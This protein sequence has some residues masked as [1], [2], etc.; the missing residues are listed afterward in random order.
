[1]LNGDQI[2]ALL[3]EEG[4]HVYR[5]EVKR[6]GNR[7]LTMPGESGWAGFSDLS[8]HRQSAY[9]LQCAARGPAA[10]VFRCED[11]VGHEKTIRM[12]G[13]ASWM[14]VLLDEPT[15]VY[16]DFDNPKNFAADGPTPGTWLFSN[17]QSGPVGREA[18]GVPAQVKAPG[19]WWGLKFNNDQLAL[20]LITPETAASYRIAP[21]AGA[22]GVG[23]ENSPPAHHFVTLAGVLKGSPAETMNRL[24]ST[25]DLKRP[26]SVD[27]YGLEAR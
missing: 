19:T 23:I 14:E 16:W 20:G 13:G 3:S 10:V 25:L 4:A 7:D 6:A 22:G 17:G 24:Q 27:V 8:S 21:G 15:P 11:A 1:M 5:W 12:Y 2:R 18:D 26:V 9:Q